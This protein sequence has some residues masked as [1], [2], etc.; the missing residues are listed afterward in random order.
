MSADLLSLRMLV[1]A[2]GQP[3]RDLWRRG[4]TL[5][6]V[7]IDFVGA[8]PA[9]AAVELAKGGIDIVVID[10]ALPDV[11]KS[12]IANIARA[13]EPAPFVVMSAPPGSRRLEGTDGTVAKPT[14]VDAARNIAEC[15]IRARIPAR[16][17]IVDDSST[18]R[19]IVRKILLASHFAMEICEADEGLAALNRL[20]TGNFDLVFLDYNMPGLN[21]LE[22]LMEIK[23]FNNKVGVVIMTSADDDVMSNLVR[24]AGALGFLKKPFYPA[25]IDA[26]LQRHYGL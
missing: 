25:D 2:A 11:S 19:S 14:D 1:V 5:T 3:A 12:A 23:R 22:T 7:P 26:L 16:V 8:S 21:G 13:M 6:S 17:M 18:M 9:T 24:A 20:R 15:C 10:F 4:A